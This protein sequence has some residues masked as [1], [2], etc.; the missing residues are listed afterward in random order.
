MAASLED[1]R[2]AMG[3]YLSDHAPK[4]FFC[5]ISL[6][7]MR[8]P[9]SDAD[10]NSYERGAILAWLATEGSPTAG[11]SPL[12]RRD[13]CAGEL[14]PNRALRQAIVDFV[15]EAKQKPYLRGSCASFSAEEL[16]PIPELPAVQLPQV[17][18]AP[19]ADNVV[20]SSGLVQA[21]TEVNGVLA[22][23]SH[24]QDSLAGTNNVDVSGEV[25]CELLPQDA[26]NSLLVTA[27]SG[28]NGAV[29]GSSSQVITVVGLRNSR[30]PLFL[31]SQ[32]AN[33]LN[34]HFAALGGAARLGHRLRLE[35]P[36]DDG[37]NGNAAQAQESLFSSEDVRQATVCDYF[38]DSVDTK[39]HAKGGGALFLATNLRTGKEIGLLLW[40]AEVEGFKFLH[41]SSNPWD[42]CQA[43]EFLL[44]DEI[45]ITVAPGLAPALTDGKLAHLLYFPT[46]DSETVPEESNIKATSRTGWNLSGPFANFGECGVVGDYWRELRFEFLCGTD[47]AFSFRPRCLVTDLVNPELRVCLGARFATAEEANVCR[48]WFNLEGNVQNNTQSN[49][50]G[51]EIEDPCIVEWPVHISLDSACLSIPDALAELF[52]AHDGTSGASGSPVALHVRFPSTDLHK[53]GGLTT[54]RSGGGLHVALFGE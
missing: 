42:Y 26:V 4:A 19:A 51:K 48:E 39:G 18:T 35:S 28:E 32:L 31:P 44:G 53:L 12:S 13:M 41:G 52:S 10:G 43:G 7:V 14:I 33:V 6:D 23:N 49:G 50:E 9:V 8:D 36:A 34:L 46:S 3:A 54:A 37:E 25:A 38:R 29:S 27:S 45:E 30:R 2:A 5:P 40:S 17:A 1:A 11:P 15:E 16:H 22:E 20:S 47:A 24:V 21:G